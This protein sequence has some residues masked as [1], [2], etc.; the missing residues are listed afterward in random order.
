MEGME[1]VEGGKEGMRSE[2]RQGL[3]TEHPMIGIPT[4]SAVGIW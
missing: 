3:D 4:S 2:G 1:R